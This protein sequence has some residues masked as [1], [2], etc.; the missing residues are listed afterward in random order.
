[1]MHLRRQGLFNTIVRRS[2][3]SAL[4][5]NATMHP[6]SHSAGNYDG[7]RLQSSL[8]SHETTRPIDRMEILKFIDTLNCAVESPWKLSLGG[9]QLMVE[10]GMT[11]TVPFQAVDAVDDDTQGGN[12]DEVEKEALEKQSMQSAEEITMNRIVLAKQEQS[13]SAKGSPAEG[14]KKADLL[15]RL[16]NTIH[17]KQDVWAMNAYGQCLKRGVKMSAK[18]LNALFTLQCQ[19][20]PMKAQEILTHLEHS[21]G[22]P[23][24]K[25]YEQLCDAVGI[26]DHRKHGQDHMLE[27]FVT[28]LRFKIMTFDVDVQKRLYPRLLVSMVKQK[29]PMIGYKAHQLYEFMRQNN[30][31]LNVQQMEEAMSFARYTRKNELPYHELLHMCVQEGHK[32]KFQTAIGVLQQLFPFNNFDATMMAM[33]AV[34][35][36]Q[37]K[38]SNYQVDIGTLEMITGAAATRGRYHICLKAWDILEA[39]GVQPSE[40]IY[41]NIVTAFIMGYKQDLNCF[42]ALGDM[43]ARGFKPSR[44]LIRSVTRSL[45]FSIGRV[46][47]AHINVASDRVEGA[48]VTVSTLNMVCSGYAELGQVNRAFAMFDDFT[49]YQLDPDE[50]TY[51]YMMEALSKAS[52]GDMQTSASLLAKYYTAAEW[53]IN[54]MT[55]KDVVINHHTLHYYVHTLG[56]LGEFD[57]AQ[58]AV[59][60]ALDVGLNVSNK[61]LTMLISECGERGDLDM[62]R[63]FASKLSE[64]LHFVEKR[65]ENWELQK[66]QA[67]L[68]AASQHPNP[69][70]GIDQL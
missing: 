66:A 40:T 46:D 34:N 24:V 41:E 63:F 37:A 20:D 68:D 22:P 36:L 30:F 67:V 49:K 32:P 43:E 44:A 1:M 53:L 28:K 26:L 9:P 64:P 31:P 58:S 39:Q 23:S 19:T 2:V 15:Q 56:N 62:A 60:D 16:K 5:Y 54:T 52:G 17:R 59:L 55:E 25:L 8:A 35:K 3:A 45:R 6:H 69:I 38:S 21:H 12:L 14:L 70:V 42:S 57:A 65:I 10:S 61:T 11:P 50:D 51:S 47:H 29:V 13:T 27:R 33:E 4:R 48:R 7:Q 18:I